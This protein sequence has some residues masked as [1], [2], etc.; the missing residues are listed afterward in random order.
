MVCL[1]L[2]LLDPPTHQLLTRPTLLLQDVFSPGPRH[3]RP[4]LS[5][6]PL[7]LWMA[8]ATLVIGSEANRTTILWSVA[9]PPLLPLDLAS[10]R[11]AVALPSRS[12]AFSTPPT[13]SLENSWTRL[14]LLLL[15]GDLAILV[16]N[17]VL[18]RACC[19]AGVRAVL[20]LALDE[21]SIFYSGDQN[22]ISPNSVSPLLPTPL[23]SLSPS[24]RPRSCPLLL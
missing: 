17:L 10:L 2:L 6:T 14:L 18:L 16:H 15:A 1:I 12:S 7:P 23:L 8:P 21:S 19:L 20:N 3:R 4:P 5:P 22:P 9:L 24:V 13:I 11:G